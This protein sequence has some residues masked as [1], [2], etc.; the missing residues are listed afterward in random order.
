MA[1]SPW[2]GTGGTGGW[3]GGGS[4]AGSGA[5]AV[6][7]GKRD[8]CEPRPGNEEDCN[9]PVS[10]QNPECGARA[11]WYCYYH[12]GSDQWQCAEEDPGEGWTLESGPYDDPEECAEEC[13]P[14][15]PGDD[16]CDGCNEYAHIVVGNTALEYWQ[17]YNPELGYSM[18]AWSYTTNIPLQTDPFEPPDYT[19]E[20]IGCGENLAGDG[21]T[22]WTRIKH[23]DAPGWGRY[24]LGATGN[25]PFGTYDRV[26]GDPAY[27][28]SSITLSA[29]SY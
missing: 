21:V 26:S 1:G 23:D 19:G 18:C 3:P 28:P 22:W 29:G 13:P 4:A 9:L 10:E 16:D 14:E 24:E 11:E 12:E 5:G 15:C 2:A 6:P 20:S 7:G 25:C 27:Y 8:P 17:I